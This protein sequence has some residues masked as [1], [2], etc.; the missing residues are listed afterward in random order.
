MARCAIMG[1]S[2]PPHAY[3]EEYHEA[4]IARLSA[5]GHELDTRFLDRTIG[6]EYRTHAGRLWRIAPRIRAQILNELFAD[7][8]IDVILDISGG[9]LAN[10][11]LPLLDWDTIAQHPKP[12]VGYSDLTTIV[13]AIVTRTQQQAVLWSPRAMLER[14]QGDVSRILAGQRIRPHILGEHELPDVPIIGG[15]LRCLAKL[16]GTPYLPTS[17][18]RLVICESLGGGLE[19]AASY[20]QQLSMAGLFD[21]AVGLILGQFT[22]IDADEDRPHLVE[23]AQEITRLPIWHAPQVGHSRDCEPVTIG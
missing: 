12:F 17:D 15:H 20:F 13:N 21:N 3:F 19:H 18:E 16:V 6:Q 4:F 5:D 9:D 2:N 7:P 11:I 10:E 22:G 1:C 8:D 14:P 23:L